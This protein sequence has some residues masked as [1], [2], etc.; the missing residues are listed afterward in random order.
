YCGS[1]WDLLNAYRYDIYE[2]SEFPSSWDDDVP[3][4][5]FEYREK[6]YYGSHDYNKYI[7]YYDKM[8]G[9]LELMDSCIID[10][11]KVFGILCISKTLEEMVEGCIKANMDDNLEILHSIYPN[12][13]CYLS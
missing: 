13:E 2:Q 10:T 11:D 3:Y 12:L 7:D 4:C 9:V 5:I 8:Q 1:V 6:Y